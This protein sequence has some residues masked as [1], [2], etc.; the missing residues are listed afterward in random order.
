MG[1]F[2]NIKHKQIKSFTKGACRAMLI[3]FGIA[4]AEAEKGKLEA[5]VYGD[6]AVKALS[7]RPGWSMIEQNLFQHKSGEKLKI[8]KEYS[9]ADVILSVVLIEME[10]FILKDD[11]PEEILGIVTDEFTKFFSAIPENEIG[12]VVKRNPEWVRMFGATTMSKFGYK[13]LK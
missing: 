10:E 11:S 2:S 8:E 7:T 6:L 4:E 12:A 9:L 13:G 3:A 5:K 1:F